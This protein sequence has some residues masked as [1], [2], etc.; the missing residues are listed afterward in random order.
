M[1]EKD[2]P[3]EQLLEAIEA[4]KERVITCDGLESKLRQLQLAHD[5]YAHDL[6]EMVEARTL[7]QRIVNKQLREEIA[8]RKVLEEELFRNKQFLENVVN[9]IT[10][11]ICVIS[12]DFTIRWANRTFLEHFKCELKDVVGRTCHEVT[13]RQQSPCQPPTDLC[14]ITAIMETRKPF[15][16]VHIHHGKDGDFYS[17]VS[18]YPIKDKHGQILEFVHIARDIVDDRK[19][20]LPER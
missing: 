12:K 19:V 9:G 18:A 2:K 17:E 3:R 6:E 4:L 10:E 11:Q 8:Q 1:N 14:P 5:R 20:R 15:T 16:T 7:S 13:H